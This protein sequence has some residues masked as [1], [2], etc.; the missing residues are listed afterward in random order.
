MKIIAI[1]SSQDDEKHVV[2]TIL[3]VGKG[4]EEESF[5]LLKSLASKLISKVRKR[6]SVPKSIFKCLT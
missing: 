3:S 1:S 6:L 5:F 2:S 4:W